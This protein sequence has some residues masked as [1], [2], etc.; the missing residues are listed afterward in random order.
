MVRPFPMQLAR[1]VGVALCLAALAAGCYR[2]VVMPGATGNRKPFTLSESATKRIDDVTVHTLANGLTL[3]HRQ[4]K[5]NDI[6]GIVAYVRH[7]AVSDPEIAGG[8]TNLMMRLLTKGTERRTADEIAEETGL[9]GASLSAAAGQDYCTVSLQCV[10]EDL[11]AAMD[12]FTDVL[13]NPIF[14]NAELDLERE[15]VLAGIRMGEDQ[16]HV[17]VGKRFRAELFGTHPYGRPVEGTPE[18]LPRISGKMLYDTHRAN[19]VPS[20]MV[21][22]VV[23]NV[24]YG[25][26]QAICERSFQHVALEKKPLFDVNKIIAPAGTRVPLYKEAKQGFIM[27]GVTT[28]PAG[29]PDEVALE[30]ATTA[31]GSGMSSR[32]FRELRDKQGLAY[33]V[34]A[35][36]AFQ[37]QQGYFYGYIGTGPDTLARAEKGLWEQ[38]RALREEP[39]PDDELQRAKNYIAGEYLRAHERNMQQARYLAYWHVSGRGVEYDRQYL[40][41]VEAVTLRDV[42]RVANK[43]FLDPTVVV[44]HPTVEAMDS[45]QSAAKPS[46]GD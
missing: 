19:F 25:T 41:D 37:R 13:Q 34:G 17:I 5:A 21:L 10:N 9:L 16:A 2:P 31:L 15:K 45:T 33:A 30:V 4:T 44:L 3:I 38:V 26:I 28:C 24:D 12:L 29:N 23:G 18:T 7:G 1:R 14:P 39:L 27:M 6:V 20:N 11:G 22:S 46:T 32:L 35:D 43:Y 42:M 36:T 40:N 8:R